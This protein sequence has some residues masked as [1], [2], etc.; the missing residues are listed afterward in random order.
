M[1]DDNIIEIHGTVGIEKHGKRGKKED[2]AYLDG[3]TVG[4][5]VEGSKSIDLN[6]CSIGEFLVHIFILYAIKAGNLS[7]LLD[8]AAGERGA[9]IYK[10]AGFIKSKGDRIIYDEDN[11]MIISL[12]GKKKIK[13][14]DNFGEKDIINFVKKLLPKLKRVLNA[15]DFGKKHHL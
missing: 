3:V 7:L 14:P 6:G 11:E 13:M 5:W 15:K 8:N 12:T 4:D 9:Y 2:E 1:G 10:K